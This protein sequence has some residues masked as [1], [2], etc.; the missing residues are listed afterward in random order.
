MVGGAA[1]DGGYAE[2]TTVP[3][4]FAL[5]LAEGVTVHVMTRGAAARRLALEL[6]AASAQDAYARPPEP[7]DRRDPV[8]PRRRT[9]PGRP[10]CTGP[11]RRP[12]R[13][14]HP[15]H[16]HASP[17]HPYPLSRAVAALADLEAG[18]FDGAAVLVNDLS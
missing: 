8:R 7:L 6:G 14:R 1:A 5:A 13:R 3:A 10:P 15:P 4:A 9:G 11:R 18:R 12:G 17:T 16:R 2:Y